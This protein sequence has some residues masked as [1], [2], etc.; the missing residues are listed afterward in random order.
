MLLL[1]IIWFFLPAAIANMFASLSQKINFLNIPIDFNKKLG[2]QRIFGKNKT[3]RGFLFGI[4]S[5]IIFLYIQKI[6][7]PYTNSFC[8]IDYSKLNILLLGFLFG[9]GALFGDLV[10]SFFKR[11][12]NINPSKPLILFD[13]IDWILMANIFVS[14]YIKLEWKIIII[15]ILL[16]TIMHPLVNII[17]YHLKLRNTKY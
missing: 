16:Y 10:K 13:Q 1:K 17:A 12:L 2:N 6:L 7:Y 15:S 14:F 3:Y 5:A 8:L 4:I 9:F 11:R